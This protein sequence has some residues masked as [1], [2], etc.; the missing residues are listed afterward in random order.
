MVAQMVKRLKIVVK[1]VDISYKTTDDTGHSRIV[2]KTLL[3]LSIYKLKYYKPQQR[4][5]KFF[6]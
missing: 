4:R 3:R 5:M 2:H 6:L 1:A